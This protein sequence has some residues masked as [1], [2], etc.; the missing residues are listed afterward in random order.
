MSQTPPIDLSAIAREL[1]L[2]AAQVAAVVALADEGNT[3]PFITRYRKERTGNLNEEQIRAIL[4]RTEILRQLAEK[5]ATVLRL[6]ETQGKLTP[7]LRKGIEQ[8]D[9]LKRLDDLYLPFRPKKRTRAA[10]A[11]ERGLEPFADAIWNQ[12][13]EI[14]SVMGAAKTYVDRS[15]ELPTPQDVLQGASDIIAERISEDAAVRDVARKIAWKIG[16]LATT[17]VDA[18]S[19]AHQSFRDYFNHTEPVG[20]VPPHR[21]LAFNRGEEEGALRVKFD[22]NDAEPRAAIA[23]HL[24]LSEHRFGEFLFSAL[25]DALDRLLTPAMEREIRRELTEKAQAHAV[26]VFAKNLR[27]LLLQPPMRGERVLAI[28]PGFRT[29]CKTVVLDET[30]TPLAQDVVYVTGNADKHAAS[31][32]RLAELMREHNCRVVAIGNGTA[33]RE[34][35]ELVAGMIAGQMPEARYVIVNEAGASIYSTSAAARDEFPNEDATVRGTISIG[36]RLQD[37]LSELVKVEPQ[38]IGVGLYQHDLD[39]KELQKS[40]DQVI[41]SCVNYVGVDLNTASVALLRHVS[42]LNQLT[43]RRVVEYRQQHGP[44]RKRTELREVPGIGQATFTQAAGF[45]KIPD[46]DD[47]LDATWI[48]PESYAAARKLLRQLLPPGADSGTV[49]VSAVLREQRSGLEIE[50]LAGDLEIGAPTLADIVDD[51]CRPGRDPRADLPGPVFRQGVMHLE[52]LQPGMEL[53]G[54]VLNVV[55]FGAFVDVGLKE[56]GLVHIS[57]LSTEYVRSPHDVIAVGDVVKVWVQS[58]DLERKR[59]ALTRVPPGQSPAPRKPEPHIARS[60]PQPQVQT[61]APQPLR[62]FGELKRTWNEGSQE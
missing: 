4:E 24:K 25:R 12:S 16:K 3:V 29:G 37:P 57:Q 35:E 17:A 55:D 48:H 36:R 26:S 20:K 52:D 59:V 11:R 10:A 50:S 43:A 2:A 53:Q 38:H 58:V 8:A 51:L 14:H 28:D 6:I 21:V 23:A 39:E 22:W 42:G 27:S 15:R 46:G 41:E 7:E 34:T 47:P 13:P 62:S 56:S 60:K 1:R 40:L 19:Q 49:D 5:K 45:L 18:T 33:C 30:G 32:A 9:S 54:T 44:F 61:G 31:Q